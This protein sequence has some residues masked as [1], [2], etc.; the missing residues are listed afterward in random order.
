MYGTYQYYTVYIYIHIYI[1]IKYDDECTGWHN[2]FR[3]I[4]TFERCWSSSFLSQL[5]HYP[6]LKFPWIFM[7]SHHS[8]SSSSHFPIK[9]RMNN[10]SSET[11][12]IY[13]SLFFLNMT[14]TISNPTIPREFSHLPWCPW[15]IIKHNFP[16][17]QLRRRWIS[18]STT[19]LTPSFCQ[20]RR[21]TKGVGATIC[22]SST[23][24]GPTSVAWQRQKG[25]VRSWIGIV[26]GE[27]KNK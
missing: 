20:G 14:W 6:T 24:A 19:G 9:N 22:R 1:C 13:G 12:P 8:P 3:A 10:P 27:E 4:P 11:Y 17:F 21:Q 2:S 26:E 25:A 23:A 15:I 7:R 18:T 16:I 5:R